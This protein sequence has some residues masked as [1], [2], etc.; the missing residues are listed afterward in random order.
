MV[1]SRAP[2]AANHAQLEQLPLELL[3]D[4]RERHTADIR[5]QNAQRDAARAAARRRRAATARTAPQ[6]GVALAAR[7]RQLAL[8]RPRLLRLSELERPA[9]LGAAVA[10]L[11]AIAIV[12]VVRR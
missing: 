8:A 12:I 4:L 6:V 7:V 11:L 9:R 2:A 3:H 1:A 5:T 10:A